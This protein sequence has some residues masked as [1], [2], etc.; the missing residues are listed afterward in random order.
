MPPSAVGLLILAAAMHATWNLLI[1]RSAERQI[2]TWWSLLVGSALFTPLLFVTGATI[3]SRAWPF[4]VASGAVEAAYFFALTRAYRLGDFSLV[5]PLARGA[6]PAFLALW[7]TIF[8]AERPSPAGLLGLAI[9]IGGL[10]VVGSGVWLGRRDN[11]GVGMGAVVAALTVALC[12]S[13]YS[14]IDGAAVRFVSPVPYTILILGLSALFCTPIIV[15]R[16]RPAAL[17]AEWRASWPRIAAVGVLNLVTYM[18]VLFA[19]SRAPVAYAGAVREIS[20]VFAAI[21]GWL[22]LD[23]RFGVPRTIGALLIFAGIIVIAAFG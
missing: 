22:W 13:I 17:V 6:A 18:L 20:V 2:F 5:Y 7:A 21:V 8:L 11:P 15:V 9:L 16:Y 4:I 19:Y 10:L 23:E 12:I 14:A 3:P 1:K